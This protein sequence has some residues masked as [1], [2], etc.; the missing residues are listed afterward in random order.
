MH[1]SVDTKIFR[2]SLSIV[3]HATASISTTPI[4][5]NI[6]IKVRQDWIMLTS[7][8]LEMAIEH[9]I[10]D[11]FNV[12]TEWDFSLPSKLLTSYVSL[13]NEDSIELELTENETVILKTWSS[14]F[15]IKWIWAEEFPVIPWIREVNSFD[16]DTKIL[17][18]WIEKT[19]FSAAE[20]NIRPTL[21]WIFFNI[22]WEDF[23]L[24][25]TDSFRLSEFK[26]T[27]WASVE[28]DFSQIIPSKTCNELRALIESDDKVRII[29]WENQAAFEF[30]T[31]K[32][33]SRL[34]NWKFPDYTNF[35]P[36][37][38]NTKAVIEKAELV[39]ALKKANLIWRENNYS[40]RVSFSSSTWILLETNETQIWEWKIEIVWS[41]EW[42]DAF[43]WINSNYMLEALSSIEASH[44][45]ITF[46]NPLSPIM[47]KPLFD[48]KEEAKKSWD[49][50][51]IIMPLK[52]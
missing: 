6:L 50:K 27:L 21:A 9:I 23:C 17:K 13:L 45:S 20:W 34:L 4:L 15:K 14:H 47:V 40:V 18:N 32:L 10:T 44:V 42:W 7:N 16:I 43:I 19:L 38:Y 41:V 28:N 35:F 12:F 26:T 1:F 2:Q 49:F 46:E 5:E 22:S 48:E 11:N 8:N 39:S 3:N 36:S 30:W 25:S 31:T 52:V 33:F 24:A 37:T 29:T 51:H